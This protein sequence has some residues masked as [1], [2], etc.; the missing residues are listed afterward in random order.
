MDGPC[1][2]GIDVS[3]RALDGCCRPGSRFQHENSPVG[4][5]QLVA[6]L[7]ALPVTLVAVE[8]T[9]GL[10]VP[11]VRALQRAGIAVAVLNP[12][13]AR[14][15]AKAS[16]QLAKTDTIDAAVLAHYAEALHPQ[17][18]LLRDEDAQFLDALVTRRRQLIDMRTME[19]NRL[20]SCP[21]PRV[22]ADIQAH[23]DW[24]AKRLKD[25]EHD[26]ADAV[27][28]NPDW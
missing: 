19:Q 11:V 6:R 16:G 24:L 12:R 3:Q 9:G 2:V 23:L 20:G 25:A 14:D 22:R 28:T 7:A 18:R 27:R 17:P 5:A 8:A 15:F 4:I 26:L 10:E 1:F 13:L 21:D